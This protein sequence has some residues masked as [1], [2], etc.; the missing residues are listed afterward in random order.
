M[1]ASFWT[2]AGAACAIVLAAMWAFPLLWALSTSLRPELETV[3]ANFHWLPQDWTLDAYRKTLGAGNVVR[4]LFNSFLVALLVT[5]VT[6]AISLMAAYAFSQLRFRGRGIV[7]GIAMLGFLLPFE[8]LLVPLFRTMHQ[9]GLINSY[10]GIVLPQVVS[11]VVIYVFKQ[12]FDAIPADFREAAVMDGA[13]PLRVLWSVYLPIS[14]NIVWAMA[15]VTFIAAWNNFLWPFIIVTSN[16]M[17]TIPLGLTQ[18]Y[19]AFG[20][21]YA[22]LMAAALLGALPVALAYVL[23][24]RR[25]TQ[26][27][28][29]ASGL[30]G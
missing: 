4:W 1:K 22:Q 30:K 19:D 17:M 13:G 23:F 28:L 11:P 26:G 24:Q 3:S 10:A 12:F 21:R 29:A 6:M 25:V 2:I 8:A 16:D 7:F 9:L 20:V 15:I 5:V 27:F 14:G 18:T